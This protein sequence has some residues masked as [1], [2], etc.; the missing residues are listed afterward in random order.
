MTAIL[1]DGPEIIR[2]TLSTFMNFRQDSIPVSLILNI[3][4]VGTG[5]A[6]DIIK[7]VSDLIQI[8]EI[9][10]PESP[11]FT[12]AAC[13]VW[14][15]SDTDYVFNLEDDWEFVNPFSLQDVVD[16]LEQNPAVS[17]VIFEQD[18]M[19][20]RGDP[21]F[22]PFTSMGYPG[23]PY[24]LN[25]SFVRPLGECLRKCHNIYPSRPNTVIRKSLKS[26]NLVREKKLAECL[27]TNS[28]RAIYTGGIVRDIGREW[29]DKT[30]IRVEKH[31]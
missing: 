18:G 7:A 28:E 12:R 25:G 17:S 29:I 26:R 6:Q 13:R 2:R 5:S 19:G 4:S 15:R 8:K 23:P 9:F 27:E 20:D 21:S 22:I 10:R 1:R 31:G 11:S 3:D 16:Y 14:A 30:G 24:L